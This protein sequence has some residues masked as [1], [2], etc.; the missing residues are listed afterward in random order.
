VA[1][2]P[3]IAGAALKGPADRLLRELGHESSVVGVAR[4]YRDLA[5]TLVIDD[6]DAH[7][8]PAVEAEGLRC[9]VAPTIMSG[10]D[11]A[12]ALGRTVLTA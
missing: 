10:P 3:I 5:A 12:A 4:L 9:V 6:A 2:S 1:V 11:E 8:A 7:L